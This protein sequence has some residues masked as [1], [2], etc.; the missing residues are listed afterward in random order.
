ML[1]L[2]LTRDFGGDV[3]I[4]GIRE[5]VFQAEQRF[6]GS[7][8]SV[9]S[10]RIVRGPKLFEQDPAGTGDT[11]RSTAERLTAKYSSGALYRRE[12]GYNARALGS[13]ARCQRRP[14]S[15]HTGALLHMSISGTVPPGRAEERPNFRHSRPS[16]A[17]NFPAYDGNPPN[18]AVSAAP[19]RQHLACS[20]ARCSDPPNG[21][22]AIV[23]RIRTPAGLRNAGQRVTIVMIAV[24]VS[25]ARRG[26]FEVA[27]SDHGAGWLARCECD[28]TSQS[29]APARRFPV[30]HH[31]SSSVRALIGSEEAS[32][33]VHS[34]GR[35]L[36][37][38]AI[39]AAGA[40]TAGS[41]T[42]LTPAS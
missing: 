33:H 35:A 22:L 28:A 2:A 13:A 32:A 3:T 24:F 1:T 4:R 25:S 21:G 5:G 40:R 34:G 8:W 17:A 26:S 27:A 6:A 14:F 12:I 38:L 11:G 18:Q 29:A 19:T 41:A 36:L 10:K 42:P 37:D 30:R 9:T 39:T 7:R 31:R 16:G 15:Q 23:C 20:V